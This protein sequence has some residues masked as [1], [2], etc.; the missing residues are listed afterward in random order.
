MGKLKMQAVQK[1]LHLDTRYENFETWD[2][3]LDFDVDGVRV[4]AIATHRW[5]EDTVRVVSPF[6]AEG[7]DYLQGFRPPLMAVALAM[8]ARQQ[9]LQTQGLTVRED[10]IRMAT[11]TYRMHATYLRIKPQIDREQQQY[12]RAHRAKL[13]RSVAEGA[14]AQERLGAEK[15]VLRQQLRHQGLDPKA[16]QAS[17]T[18]LKKE[19]RQAQGKAWGLESD[20]ETE[21]NRIKMRLIHQALETPS[22]VPAPLSL[23]KR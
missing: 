10:C 12:A 15:S 18:G 19:A 7:E 23:K 6:E 14:L 13:A 16:Y 2:E 11:N 21:F 17:L 5:R 8:K 20:M 3:A 22:E 1:V 4:K 9:R